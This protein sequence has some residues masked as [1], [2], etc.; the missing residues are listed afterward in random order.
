M[1]KLKGLFAALI[2]LCS[3]SAFAG[4]FD[5]SQSWCNYGGGIEKGDVIVD[6]AVGLNGNFFN[7]FN[8]GWGIPYL[9]ASFDVAAPIWK[10]PFTF[11]GSVGA[12]IS[13]WDS[14]V[15]TDMNVAAHA[16]YHIMLP[17]E[18]LDVYVGVR[19][20]ANLG[21]SNVWDPYFGFYFDGFL[22]AHYFLNDNFGFIAEFGYPV[23]LK[24]GV[25]FKF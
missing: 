12:N 14:Y 20:G 19:L 22:G 18:N 6:V 13:G 4:D 11:G 1:K 3:T 8:G 2:M 17:V 10:L 15:V 5:W 23:W 7:A 25:T 16:K 24:A 9:H 21:F